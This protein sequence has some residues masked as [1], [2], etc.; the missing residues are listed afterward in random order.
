MRLPEKD[1][2]SM[3]QDQMKAHL[4]IATGGRIAEELI[5]GKEKITNGA[6]SDI[7]MVTN[8]ARKMITEWGMSEKLGRLRY[9][10]D[11]EEVF[12]GHSVAQSKNLS[13]ATASMIDEEIRKLV[14][15]AEIHCKKILTENINEL[16]IVA[17]GLLEYETLSGDEI[18]DLINGINPS[19]DDFDDI[20]DSGS[21]TPTPS[22]P[23]S[24]NSVS[25]QTQ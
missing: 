17:K 5:F 23:K 21:S 14:D 20:S 8:L 16:H 25:P 9:N 1:Q 6:A 18:K 13:D 2:L 4:V 15:D 19:R 11:S 7:Q 24:S 12:L 22:V 10:N 3:K